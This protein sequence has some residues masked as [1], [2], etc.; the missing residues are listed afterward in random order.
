MGDSFI[1]QFIK[2]WRQVGAI[3]PSSIFLVEDML[4]EVDWNSVR[5]IVELGA[6]SGSFTKEILKK[7]HPEAK[8]FVFEIDKVFIKKLSKIDDTRM[9]L[10]PD[11]A[12]NISRYLN[13]EKA[14]AIISGIPLSN[15]D[16]KTKSEIIKDSV[17]NMSEDG[18]FLQFQYF[19]ESYNFLKRHFE[20]IKVRFTLF[21]TPPAFFYI[22]RL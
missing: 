13:G 5:L 21:N 4:E 11:S 12:T 19:P 18:V 16:N 17:K 15:L 7:M 14:G 1:F 2:K 9:T 10:I 3:M 8:L 22:C 6:G 20:D